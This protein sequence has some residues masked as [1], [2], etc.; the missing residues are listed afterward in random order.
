MYRA[1]VES[2]LR[3]IARQRYAG[4]SAGSTAASEDDALVHA[5]CGL[6][7]IA[8]CPGPGYSIAQDSPE[9]HP[10]SDWVRRVVNADAYAYQA[11][12]ASP[13][14][15]LRLEGVAGSLGLMLLPDTNFLAWDQLLELLER[16]MPRRAGRIRTERGPWQVCRFERF[17]VSQAR[18]IAVPETALSPCGRC[19]LNL[20]E[21]RQVD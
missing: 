21:R 14:E 15:L 3:P 17:E 19:V 8:C 13:W 1:L 10:V 18:L 2:M 9:R 16:R 12:A 11:G 20:T 7:L 4:A 5:L 6:G